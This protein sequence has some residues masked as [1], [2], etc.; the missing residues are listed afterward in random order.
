MKNSRKRL[1]IVTSLVETF[2]FS[3]ALAWGVASLITVVVVLAVLWVVRSAP[4]DT[5]TITTGPEG[6]SFYRW[7]KLYQE[8]LKK[9][10]VTL[11]IH[12]SAGSL[13][14]LQQLQANDSHVDIGFVSGGLPEATTAQG[15]ISLGS[16]AYQPLLVFY[17]SSTPLIRLSDLAGKRLSVGMPGSGTR[18]LSLTLLKANGITGAPTKFVDSDAGAAAAGLLEGKLDAVFLMGDSASLD[19]LRTLMR[20]PDIQLFNF[21]QADA[22][23]RRRDYL[24]KIVLPQGSIDLGLNLPAHDVVL[25]GPTVELV[26]RKELNAALSDLLLDVAKKVHGRP[27][28]MQKRGEFPAPLEHDFPLS[29]DAVQYYKQ[30]K[31]FFNRHIDSFWLASLLNRSAFAIVPLIL[32]LIPAMRFFPVVYRFTIQLRL[33]RWYRPLLLL[34]REAFGPLTHERIRE[35]LER[36]DGIEEA[37]NHLKVPAS[38]ASQFYWLRGH[39]DFVRQRLKTVTPAESLKRDSSVA[40]T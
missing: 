21:V 3:I 15:L 40:A 32:I 4:P 2:G 12:S 37:V 7:A 27:S 29:D 17:R 20:A 38:F 9:D 36:L 5:I 33:Y 19:T 31:R 22:Y 24:N 6:S 26:A 16:V 25:V 23:V 13:E 1:P 11:N 8:E 30:G 28:V 18:S 35:L 34:E 10:G 14:N 39:I